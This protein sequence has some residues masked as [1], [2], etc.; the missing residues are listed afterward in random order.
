MNSTATDPQISTTEHRIADS[1]MLA[2]AGALATLSHEIRT[3][4][5]G[6]LGMAGLLAETPL[7]ETQRA[8]LASLRASGEHLLNLVNDIL[9]L[10][11]L[12][13]GRLELEKDEVDIESLLQG[14]TELLSPRAHAAGL[15]IAWAMDK[16][17]PRLIAD[18]GRLR[19]VLFNLAGNAVKM[20][21]H[22]GVL[23]SARTRALS[24][25]RVR[26]R[27]AVRDTGP[28]VAEEAKARIFEE[29]VQDPDGEAAGGAGLGLAIVRRI[30][31]AMGAI[32]SVTNL[33]LDESS[34]WGAEFAL[35]ADFPKASHAKARP[36]LP[37]AGR[38]L[39]VISSSPV[40]RESAL[41]QIRASGARAVLASGFE[42]VD[43]CY[44]AVLVDPVDPH[45]RTIARPPRGVAAFVMLTPEA[46][47]QIPRYK[48][49]GYEGYL[50]KPLRRVSII[51]RLHAALGVASQ[52]VA[53]AAPLRD[54]ERA[55]QTLAA[56]GLRVLLAEDNAVNAMLA[57]ALLTRM[58]CIVDR[59]AS[60]LEAVDA[61]TSAPYNLILMDVRMPG[62]DGL[63]ATRQLRGRGL[64]TPILALTANAFE[65][66][67]RA[68]MEAGMDEFLTKP[69][70]PP[71]LA[72]MIA[73]FI[74]QARQQA[75][76]D[77][78]VER[79]AG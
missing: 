58:G 31:E 48:A 51:S 17:A 49:A 22:G 57:T 53:E 23:I 50:I 61:A 29:F 28:G 78:Q 26:L 56:P 37:L 62:M 16:D 5:N 1:G 20:S 35:E 76:Q 4:L 33:R 15:N 8:Y 64:K 2:R 79:K 41:A 55:G 77:D 63:E 7:D 74:D 73:R 27:I 70:A 9:D 14:V 24:G 19:Q 30:T 46:R 36:A 10:A 68:C 60:G 39:A 12:E 47:D 18:D 6:V 54:D 72:A 71:A 59:A 69:I 42:G 21:R 13:A 45:P 11:K 38:T 32:V 25:D 3:P 65:D 67:R 44:D 75:D 43:P 40:V 34:Y 52:V 66:D